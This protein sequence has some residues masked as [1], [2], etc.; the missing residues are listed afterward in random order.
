MDEKILVVITARGGSK[1]VPRKNIRMVA[2]KPL[3][4]YTIE[5]ALQVRKQVHRIIVSTEDD[6]IAGISRKFGA[7]VPFMRPA[8]LAEDK[9]PSLPVLQHAL[10]FVEE[11]DSTRMDWVLLLQ[12]ASPLRT[13]EDILAALELARKGGCDSIISVVQTPIH[14]LIY[15]THR[16]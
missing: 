7:E 3:I 9:T 11:Q 16:G 1:G 13:R 2:G 10:R 15:E 12:P 4:A 5:T 6:E 8:E 14:P